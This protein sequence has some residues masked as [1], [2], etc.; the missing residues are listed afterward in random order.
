M[1]RSPAEGATTTH[2]SQCFPSSRGVALPPLRNQLPHDGPGRCECTAWLT[3]TL[4]AP[5]LISWLA[6]GCCCCHFPFAF[7]DPLR[8]RDRCFSRE[9]HETLEFFLTN[10]ATLTRSILT[11]GS[12]PDRNRKL[13]L[14]LL[15]VNSATSCGPVTS[16]IALK[17][18]IAIRNWSWKHFKLEK[19]LTYG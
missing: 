1:R 2:Y 4:A 11:D 10:L 6:G 13:L 17:L 14:A 5:G 19:P 12:S 8:H 16:G 9:M 15:L 18:N 7:M 3:S